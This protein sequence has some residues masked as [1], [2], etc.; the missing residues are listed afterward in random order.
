MSGRPTESELIDRYF[1]PL[2]GRAGLGLTDDAA[3]L[4]P[5]SGV[6]WIVT[7]DM[8][9]EGVDFLDDAAETIAAKALRVNLSDLAAKGAEP[10]AYLLTLGLSD[11]WTEDWV[12]RFAA[13]LA[14]DHGRYGVE[15]IGGDM[16][17]SPERM[18]VSVTAFGRV[19]TGRMVTRDGA[20]AGDIIFVSGTIGDSALGLK[21]RLGEIAALSADHDRL[22]RRYL[23][24]EP[25]VELI[26]VLRRLATAA[27]DISDG[28]AGDLSKLCDASGVG[29]DVIAGHVPVSPAVRME[30]ER[31]PALLET[32]LTGGD[33]YEILCTVPAAGAAEFQAQAEAAGVVCRAIGEIRAE[34]GLVFMDTAGDPLIFKRLGYEH[35]GAGQ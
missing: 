23:L 8:I 24:P 14:R 13:G 34:P 31:N 28:L 7:T 35:F 19:P 3:V 30:V 32:V 21:A 17:R 6:E 10:F 25:R 26:P 20:R 33:D 27:M 22:L 4:A 12:A 16:G 18:M 5:E 2:A 29:A 15:L 11:R 1:R 9:V